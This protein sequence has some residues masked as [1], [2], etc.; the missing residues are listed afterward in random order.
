MPEL[1]VP[2]KLFPR[3]AR[4]EYWYGKTPTTG[5][6]MPAP[7]PCHQPPGIMRRRPAIDLFRSGFW[8]FWSSW[9]RAANAIHWSKTHL[10]WSGHLRETLLFQGQPV[11]MRS[12]IPR[13]RAASRKFQNSTA[14]LTGRTGCRA[15][16]PSA[17]WLGSSPRAPSST[18]WLTPSFQIFK[19]RAALRR[20]ATA[21]KLSKLRNG[22]NATY[23][24]RRVNSGK[25]FDARARTAVLYTHGCT[26]P[27]GRKKASFSAAPLAG[28]WSESEV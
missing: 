27:R 24:P 11:C 20:P 5:I 21:G 28:D 26:T 10:F 13:V 22:L 12:K 17:G 23:P 15:H 6:V 25:G 1:L 8:N 19:D 14:E 7:T 3:E 4:V 9:P 2:G 18:V 16:S